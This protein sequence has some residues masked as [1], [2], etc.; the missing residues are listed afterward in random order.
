MSWFFFFWT[1]HMTKAKGRGNETHLF[2][3]RSYQAI[4]IS[5]GMNRG[6]TDSEERGPLMTSATYL[7]HVLSVTCVTQKVPWVIISTLSWKPGS[8]GERKTLKWLKSQG[9]LAARPELV[10]LLCVLVAQSCPSLCGPVDCS[11]PGS[12]VHGISQARIL[13]W[14]AIPFSRGSSQPRDRTWVSCTASGF[15]TSWAAREALISFIPC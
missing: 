9:L 6:R 14:A 15:F 10:C 5:R 13:E 8:Q 12:S 1:N 2:R 3:G 4:R 7:L 11:P